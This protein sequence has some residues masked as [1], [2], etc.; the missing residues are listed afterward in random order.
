MDLFLDAVGRALSIKCRVFQ[1]NSKG[2]I[3]E[4]DICSVDDYSFEL[5]FARYDILH[6]DPILEF[7]NIS[8]SGDVTEV[9]SYVDQRKVDV[10]SDSDASD[11]NEIKVVGQRKV[12]EVES[13][14]DT[15]QIDEIKSREVLLMRVIEVSDSNEDA[16]INS[17]YPS[18]HITVI[19]HFDNPTSEELL[20]IILYTPD[21]VELDGRV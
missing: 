21:I 19:S 3:I 1:I 16:S 13:D 10:E 18:P 2:N 17:R 9:D 14:S 20:N 6:V 7:K 15:S 11:I 12:G 5:Y 4:L 8:N